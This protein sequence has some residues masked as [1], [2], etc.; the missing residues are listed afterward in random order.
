MALQSPSLPETI[1]ASLGDPDGLRTVFERWLS[2]R[3]MGAAV[4]S[5]RL[6]AHN[7]VLVDA[8]WDG[9]PR[10]LVVHLASESDWS[11]QLEARWQFLTLQRLGTQL[12]RAAVPPVL[13]CE[14]DPGPLGVPFFVMSRLDGLTTAKYETP[15][16]FA[17]WITEASAA[18]RAHLQ[19]S[20]LEQLA[21]V[22]SAVPSDFAFLDRR[23]RGESALSA[24][25]RQTAQRYEAVSDRGLRAPLI[26][27]GLL[28]LREHWPEE[29]GPVLCWGDARID[30]V[31]FR[32]FAAVALTGW[33]HATLG[34]REMDLGA[35][36]FHHRF[37]DDLARA[38]GRRGLP[39]FLR[40]PDVV[41]TYNEI[42]GFL[43]AQLDFYVTY[44]A[45]GHAID[46][47]RSQLR[48]SAFKTLTDLLDAEPTGES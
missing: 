47:L 7:T 20:T 45:V 44:A 42:T 31:T 4:A 27:R 18:E 15:Y 13:W 40:P 39:D 1:S 14:D 26:E 43:P 2:T 36:V 22:H 16:T 46:A 41:G 5:A 28:W 11:P 38:A 33:R 8:G 48:T 34:P 25:L 30:N 12:V 21:R 19:R 9:Q 23:R 29:S 17:S 37:A 10:R 35:M 6:T 32:D 24:H 3:Q